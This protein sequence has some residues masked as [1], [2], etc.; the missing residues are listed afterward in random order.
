MKISC[1]N[2]NV[3][4]PYFEITFREKIDSTIDDDDNENTHTHTQ[5]H[6]NGNE[7]CKRNGRRQP[8]KYME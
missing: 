3:R 1:E 2:N 8:M 5:K 4:T 7:D 6:E